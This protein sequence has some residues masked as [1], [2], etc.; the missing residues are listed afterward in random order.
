MDNAHIEANEVLVDCRSVWKIF[1]N[2]AAAAIEA[3]EKRGLSKTDVLK[4]FNCV[5]GVSGADLQVRRG[6]STAFVTISGLTDKG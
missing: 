3:V 2:R 6:E 5:V 1:G 4:E